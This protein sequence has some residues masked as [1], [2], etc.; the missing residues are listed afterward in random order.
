MSTEHT[1]GVEQKQATAYEPIAVVGLAGRFPGA[2]DVTEFWRNLAEERNSIVHQDPTALR[3]AGV[4]EEELASP[5]YVPAVAMMP[6]ADLFDARLFSMTPREATVRDP[7]HRVFL[8]TVHS[9]LENAGYDPFAVPHTTGVFGGCAASGYAQY[10]LWGN[11]AA[12]QMDATAL[13]I[14]ANASYLPTLTSYK[15]S[16][17]GPS[18]AVATACSTS[19]VALHM[20]IGS[21]HERSC[22]LAVAGGIEIEFPY[23]HGY[24]WSPG[25]IHSQNGVCRP[26]DAAAD[27]TVFGSGVGVVVLKRLSD[28]LADG[29]PIRGIIRGSAVNNDG[30]DKVSFGAPSVSGQTAVI[31]EAMRRSG[32][33]PRDIGYVEAHGTG[34]MLGDPLE[35]TALTQAYEEM[36]GG[37]NLAPGSI[38]LGSVKSNIGH[39][40]P[41]AGVAGL[42]KA[43]LAM[44]NER[45]PATL[46]YEKSNPAIDFDATFFEV[47]D[48]ARPWPR[49]PGRPRIAAVSSFGV[50]GTNAHVL[51][52]EPPALQPNPNSGRPRLVVWSGQDEAAR[53]ATGRAYGRYFA[54]CDPADFDAAAYTTQVGRTHHAVRAAVIASSA[55][56]VAEAIDPT[57][58]G[59][60]NGGGRSARLGEGREMLRSG[61]SSRREICFA[62]PGQGSQRVRM[63]YGLYRAV[64][65]FT[66]AMD[67][68]LDLFA[69]HGVELRE[70]WI[71]GEP[72]ALDHTTLAQPALF[73]VEYAMARA[74]IAAGVRPATVLGH[75]LG[76]LTA[77]AVAGVF[78][79]PDAVRLVAARG[80]HMGGMP[81]GSMLAVA[82]EAKRIPGLNIAD[83]TVAAVNGPG[84]TTVSGPDEAIASLKKRLEAE[85]VACK[86]LTTSHAFHSPAMA[87]AAHR[88][89]RELRRMELHP[90]RIPLV[91]AATGRLVGEVECTDPEYWA[92]Q[93]TE[94]VYFGAA[95]DAVLVDGPTL[96]V[97][98]GPAQALTSLLRKHRDVMR[99]E[100]DV[101]PLSPREPELE[102]DL[103]AFLTALGS[104]Y[105]EGHDLSLPLDGPGRRVPL[106]GYAYQRKRYWLDAATAAG[107]ATAPAATLQSATKPPLSASEENNPVSPFT[108]M[109]WAETPL[110]PLAPAAPSRRALVL[111]PAE[112]EHGAGLLSALHRSGH[113]VM[114]VRPG[115]QLLLGEEEFTVRPAV[116]DDLAAVLSELQRRGWHPDT[117][118]HAWALSPWGPV[119]AKNADDQIADA[120]LSLLTLIREGTR[121]PVDGSLP[122]VV[123]F[124]SNA[125]DVSGSER[126]HPVK[127][128]ALGL[129]RT[130]PQEAPGVRCRLIDMDCAV[131]EQALAAELVHSG[132]ESVVAWRGHRRWTSAERALTPM[133][134]DTAALR[135]EGVYL[136]TGGLGG[137]G[138]EIAKGLVATGRRPHLALLGRRT[139]DGERPLPGPA[140]SRV[141]RAVEEMRALGAKVLTLSCDITDRQEVH[142]ALRAVREA[143]GAIDGVVHSAGIAGDGVLQLRD[144]ADFQRVLRPKV[145]GALLLQEALAD[146]R[147]PDFFVAFS[148]RSGTHGLVGSGDYSAA[149]AFLD[150]LAANAG[151]ASRHLSIGWPTWREVGMA[152]SSQE[153]EGV[154]VSG[155]VV[156]EEVLTAENC[157]ALDEH[158][159]GD[160]PVMPGTGQ[161]DMIVRAW[162]ARAGQD[163][164]VRLED[165]TFVRPLAVPAPR[166]VRIV[167]SVEEG[168]DRFSLLSRS[169]AGG[170]WTEHTTGAVRL[171]EPLSRHVDLSALETSLAAQKPPAAPH[172]SATG[173]VSFGPRW[174]NIGRAVR[175]AAADLVEI[176]LPGEFCSDLPYHPLHPA[177]LDG[178]TASAQRPVSANRLPFMYRALTCFAPLPARFMVHLRY[179]REDEQIL[180]LDLD[181]I[182][183][184]GRVLVAIE[185]FALRPVERNALESALREA[186]GDGQRRVL[187]GGVTGEE[188]LP[189]RTGVDLFLRLL[190]SRT[191][192]HVLVRPYEGGVPT[193][194]PATALTSAQPQPRYE[195]P[196]PVAAPSPGVVGPAPAPAAVA[197]AVTPAPAAAAEQDEVAAVIRGFWA[198]T[199]GLEEI[200][201]DDDFFEL[202][203]D[204]LSAIQLMAR[205]REQ[206]G[207]ELSVALL[208]E[209][210]TLALL[211]DM[212]R[213]NR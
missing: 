53:D 168:V 169:A 109:S 107:D 118:V 12:A 97:E 152:A 60:S 76:E 81:G 68:C 133:T 80:R 199:L 45:I 201:D 195:A 103:R 21:L 170:A 185:G 212:V 184:D 39:L 162:Q 156:L 99:G 174:A 171:V 43:L 30:S 143:F 176:A 101:V 126:V 209:C 113:H 142:S 93:L 158:R 74:L 50:G 70:S 119:V 139:P 63:A 25:S 26:F 75:S 173:V 149:N 58:A 179:R 86:L 180:L 28:A 7:Q 35:I 196:T 85:G 72:E 79:L 34:T 29:D 95:V 88:L 154:D 5:D 208:F 183:P 69:E 64:P 71:S 24:T 151:S 204:S 23:R 73:A 91:S 197:V 42:I 198:E 36:S 3:D 59:R 2:A 48:R 37:A 27:G 131:E 11:S 121:R 203:G 138:L 66:E 52:E 55:S 17:G 166:R 205:I 187:P 123:V 116:P 172:A 10:H 90:P 49:T 193:A 128:M 146:Q 46:H 114:R 190:N 189:P 110:P 125:L 163:A 16:L 200:E 87:E 65:G 182:D 181:L 206:F 117:L 148:S 155:T 31:T 147:R 207:V 100:S 92:R 111:L 130:F 136:I 22:D 14:A 210:P 153:G 56:E 38:P 164:A 194:L 161:L 106:P 51:V 6:D 47:V 115:D 44:E 78:D 82:L 150:A 67:E 132:D 159:I 160:V 4:R 213:Q 191:P 13:G 41:A 188:G 167:S 57:G 127:S 141:Q 61:D 157:W 134:R 202:G 96:V 40:G 83:V 19:L 8:E 186:D 62:F 211:A 178:A 144:P 1:A 105:V 89:E 165:V 177:L 98:V 129:V 175:G 84:Q 9:A 33:S 18:V 135:E 140:A 137:L 112:A 54:E 102:A 32:L 145:L 120:C 192:A 77:A 20:A 108:V 122:E 104:I 15:L 124:S 94:P